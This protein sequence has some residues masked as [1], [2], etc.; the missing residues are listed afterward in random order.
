MDKSRKTDGNTF[1][2]INLKA[3]IEKAFERKLL[4][5][6]SLAVCIAL[7]FLY[8]KLATP[9]YKINAS[10]LI[11]PS[12]ENRMLGKN[13]FGE[14]GV[15]LIGTEKNLYNEIGI[16]TSYSLIERTLQ[17]LDF[18]VS[19][20][21]GKWY[22]MVENY[23]NFAFEVELADS[24]AQLHGLPFYVEMLSEDEY[25]LSLKGSE[26]YVS[27]PKTGTE[28]EVKQEI[29]FSDTFSFGEP[30]IQDYFH[31]TV[32][33][34]ACKVNPEDFDGMDLSF[35]IN[36]MEA[37]TNSFKRRLAVAKTDIKSD[38]LQ[39]E[40]QGPLVEK[41][42]AFLAKLCENFINSKFLERDEIA[43]SK[44]SFIRN[45]L[46]S[47]SDSL[48]R[49]ER[50]LASFKRS[51]NAVNLTKT[52][53]NSLDQLQTLES[54]RGQ[55]ELNIK[56]YYTL[57]K[58]LDS[59]NEIEKIIAPSIAGIADP[60]LNHNLLE[61]KKLNTQ[62]TRL[63]FYKGAKSYDLEVIDKQ[64]K[65][66][67]NA[68]KEN[69]RNL[70]QAS[71]LTFRDKDQRIASLER[72][73]SQL[74]SNEKKLL[75]YQRKSNLYEN[76][77]NYLSQELAKAGIAKAE[78]LSDT[79]ILDPPRMV[80][81]G[82]I[83]PLKMVVL[84][85]ALVFGFLLPLLW[86]G[87][88]ES[89]GKTIDGINQLESLSA[90]PV[91]ARIGHLKK[92][93]G[94]PINYSSHRQVEESF[95]DLGANLQFLV[96]NPE[97][98]IIG[99]TSTISGEGK[100]FCAANLGIGLAAAGK[101]VLMIDLDFRTPSLLKDVEDELGK[102]LSDYLQEEAIRAEEIIHPHPELPNLHFI[103]TRNKEENPHKLLSS[104]RLKT[105]LMAL[106]LHYDYVILDSAAVGLVSD[107]LLVSKLID[108]HLFVLRRKVS[109]LSFLAD[110]EHLKEMG[111]LENT[112]LIFNDVKSRPGKYGF[113][114]YRNG[115][116]RN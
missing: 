63:K 12:G 82:P 79:K 104:Q 95:R 30:V 106:R 105:L 112:F 44:E 37:L 14:G 86:I 98:N 52:A 68:L 53:S 7:A 101:R 42:K 83:S 60:L 25:R 43:S 56:Y 108:I 116:I 2:E 10:L 111:N 109:R 3:L 94:S 20:Y 45:Q 66:T 54:E 87:F 76:L 93:N 33:K 75:D 81:H 36:S 31:F 89:F 64:I 92:V 9:I 91:A 58:Y 61:L 26:F 74:P 11:D 114:K 67:A 100:T 6:G 48:S 113:A 27:D 23:G 80:G 88:S 72:K 18:D 35:T 103:S 29:E 77:F 85:L 110:I 107:Y 49:A 40:I 39:L 97:K 24:S 62:K 8:I 5:A 55:I 50:R 65:N 13:K 22:K 90:I 15:D 78:D 84:I 16:L 73:M 70:V 69:L 71:R 99:L 21:S 32:R 17:D 51:T 38:I 57:L 41:E 59:G 28:H 46:A 102:G 19:Y 1:S 4:F 115:K 47:I 34:P 96:S